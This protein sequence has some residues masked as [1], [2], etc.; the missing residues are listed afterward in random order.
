MDEKAFREGEMCWR[1]SLGWPRWRFSGDE[2]TRIVRKAVNKALE[3]L[4]MVFIGTPRDA[5][6]RQ[7]L[8]QA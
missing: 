6:T 3:L 1:E 4:E 5:G 2:V 7:A 8:S